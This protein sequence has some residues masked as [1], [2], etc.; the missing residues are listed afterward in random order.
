MEKFAFTSSKILKNTILNFKNVK[1]LRASQKGLNRIE[2][3]NMINNKKVASK[4]LKKN[5][6]IKKKH[7]RKK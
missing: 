7:F 5:E 6:L 3:K 4:I 2:I 1:F